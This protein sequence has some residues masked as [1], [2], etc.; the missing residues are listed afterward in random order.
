[1]R[2]DEAQSERRVSCRGC[3]YP[4]VAIV[5]ALVLLVLVASQHHEEVTESII[6]P[7]EASTDDGRHLPA[8]PSDKRSP[9]LPLEPRAAN[10]DLGVAEREV[11]LRRRAEGRIDTAYRTH[12]K[13]ITTG[14]IRG[15]YLYVLYSEP[16]INALT[17]IATAAQ[18]LQLTKPRWDVV[19]MASPNW[20]PFDDI[21]KVVGMFDRIVYQEPFSGLCK[22]SP[23]KERLQLSH[24]KYFIW[25]FEE[26]DFVHFLDFDTFAVQ[27]MDHVGETFVREGM[28]TVLIAP[29]SGGS[30]HPKKPQTSTNTGVMILRPDKAMMNMLFSLAVD[31]KHCGIGDQSILQKFLKDKAILG[32]LDKRFN[33]NGVLKNCALYH[34]SGEKKPWDATF[35]LT[36][37]CASPSFPSISR[38]LQWNVQSNIVRDDIYRY[39]FE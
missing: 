3:F 24:T 21:L 12:A 20:E 8:N 33:C 26:Y 19:L 39:F 16:S 36:K 32:C 30:C 1:M 9:Y 17:I 4:T 13:P 31:T 5:L 28:K 27:N 15:A 25:G 29:T 6:V 34:F 11:F 23:G 22:V 38:V 37:T 14:S 10:A 7:D 35:A 2:E 18:S